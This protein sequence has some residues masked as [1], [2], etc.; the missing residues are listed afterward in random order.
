LRDFKSEI[1][2]NRLVAERYRF[3]LEQHQSNGDIRP[4]KRA[5]LLSKIPAILKSLSGV[6][7]TMSKGREMRDFL[8]D[9]FDEIVSLFLK[10]M[11]NE[12]EVQSFLRSMLEV[13]DQFLASPEVVKSSIIPVWKRY[14]EG[15]IPIIHI[16]WSRF[17]QFGNKKTN[18]WRGF[19]N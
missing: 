5:K 3:F 19:R 9:L 17:Q 16:M 7:N 15:L 1:G 13:S 8:V 10:M 4:E 12:S 6:A 14:L 11:V 2:S 18:T